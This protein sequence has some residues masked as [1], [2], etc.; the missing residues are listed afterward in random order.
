MDGGG[1]VAGFGHALY[2]AEDPRAAHLADGARALAERRGE[3]KL[4][5]TL[6]AIVTFMSPRASE[7]IAVNM[8]FWSAAVYHLMGIPPGLYSSIFAIGRIPGWTMHVMEQHE[9]NVLL[10]PRLRYV[11]ERDRVFVPIDE[12]A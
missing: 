5:E 3:T 11:G 9:R 4:V 12:R 2:R 7:G 1:R 6:G 10:R 8:D